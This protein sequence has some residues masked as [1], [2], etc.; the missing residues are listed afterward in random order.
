VRSGRAQ[1]SIVKLFVMLASNGPLAESSLPSRRQGRLI[2]MGRVLPAIGRALVPPTLKRDRGSRR[3]AS[4]IA[5][6]VIKVCGAGE[7]LVPRTN[8]KV[9]EVG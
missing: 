3:K 5:C 8:S 9:P 1:N 7:I 6:G 2:D 4:G